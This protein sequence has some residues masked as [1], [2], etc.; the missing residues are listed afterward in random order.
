MKIVTVVAL[1][2]SISA[3]TVFAGP[4]IPPYHSQDDFLLTSPGGMGFG[5]YG[6]ANPAL[7]K[8]VERPDILFTW[9]DASDEWNDLDRWGLFAGL[10]V[11]NLGFGMI[12]N[13]DTQGTLTDYRMSVAFGDRRSSFGLGYGWSGG[14]IGEYNRGRIVTLGSLTRPI[15]HLS[16]GLTGAF[17]TSGNAREGVVDLAVRP[18]A[19]EVVAVFGDYA[20][21]NGEKAKDGHWSTGVALELLPGIRLA[22][23]YFDTHGFSVGLNFSLGH[24]GLTSQAHFDD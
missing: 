4:L 20:I 7:L 15:P 22:G 13:K 5:L 17:A 18:L 12:R 21:Q 10:P 9:S 3:F 6:Y 11:P 14:H 2:L 16:V 8:Y 24:M 1:L 19:N 23:R